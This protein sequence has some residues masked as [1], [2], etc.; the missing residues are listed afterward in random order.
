[1]KEH[2]DTSPRVA[3]M[4]ALTSPTL[5]VS[6]SAYQFDTYKII[7]DQRFDFHESKLLNDFPSVAISRL[8]SFFR[9]FLP[10]SDLQ[11][12]LMNLITIQFSTLN[13]VSQFSDNFVIYSGTG[14]F[15]TV[16]ILSLV[17]KF[18]PRWDYEHIQLHCLLLAFTFA[19]YAQGFRPKY[20]LERLFFKKGNAIYFCFPG[21]VCLHCKLCRHIPPANPQIFTFSFNCGG[22]DFPGVLLLS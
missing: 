6:L 7:R 15:T 5:S 18:P 8:G 16:L 1:M 22:N 10:F 14:K 3:S 21:M 9:V 11:V 17:C 12:A 13:A 2:V 19:F 20:K 4:S